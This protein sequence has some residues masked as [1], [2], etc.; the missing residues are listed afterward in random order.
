MF[1]VPTPQEFRLFVAGS[2]QTI[3]KACLTAGVHPSSFYRWLRGGDGPPV[4]R[5]RLVVEKLAV[6][7]VDRRD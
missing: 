3:R 2:G 5:L 4:E 6:T 1:K 7:N